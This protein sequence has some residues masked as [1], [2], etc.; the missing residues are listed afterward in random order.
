MDNNRLL[1]AALAYASMGIY[2]FPCGAGSKQPVPYGWGRLSTIDQATIRAWW[3]TERKAFDSWRTKDGK[4][5]HKTFYN[6]PAYNIGIDLARSGFFVVDYDNKNGNN[7][8]A[9]RAE[10]KGP[11]TWTVKTP[12]GGGLHD[13]YRGNADT[14]AGIYAGVDVR[15]RGGL[16]IAPPSVV[17]GVAYTWERAPGLYLLADAD[18]A[19]YNFIAPVPEGFDGQQH[20]PA[21]HVPEAIEQGQRTSA[22]VALA[23]SLIGKGLTPAAAEA[24]IREEN[25][26]RCTPP[27]TDDELML[28]VFPSLRREKWQTGNT[29]PYTRDAPVNAAMLEKLRGIDPANSKRYPWTDNGAARLFMDVCGDVCMYAADAKKW[30]S[31]DGRKWSKDE[32]GARERLRELA[33][34]LT[35]YA[36]RDVADDKRQ[37]FLKWCM[38]WQ[39]LRQRETILKDAQSIAPV[40]V[41]QFD[42]DPLVLNL[43]NGIFSLKDFTIKPH[44]AGALLSHLANV[45][46]DPAA[47]F[48]R[49]DRFIDE[50]TAGDKDTARYL[51][52][53]FGYSLTAETQF[54]CAFL[55]YGPTSRNGKTTLIEA[56]AHMMGDYAMSCDPATLTQR[57]KAKG[58]E[59]SPD[60]VRLYGARLVC[61]GEPPKNMALN[62]ARLKRMT[63]GDTISARDLYESM[64]EYSPTFTIVFNTN[65]LLQVDDLTVFESDRL[66]VVP[67]TVHFSNDK[68][69]PGLK[70][71]FRTPECAAAI[72]NWALEGLRLLR[73]EGFTP[74]R[75]VQEATMD[76]RRTQDKMLRFI[77]D[78][79]ELGDGYE[80]PIVE[81]HNAFGTWCNES[82][83]RGVT[84][85]AFRSMLEER[86][87]Y[88]RKKRPAGTG[89]AGKPIAHTEGIRLIRDS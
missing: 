55:A 19:V 68:R 45:A 31:Y 30:L 88:T 9:R 20:K 89:R 13:W 21:Y 3:G 18:T 41:T 56:V 42:L 12:H 23:G 71:A 52:K 57:D 11:E 24:A 62:A 35:V 63:G 70:E 61:V 10:C 48:P 26:A 78:C 46:Y 29:A 4:K 85:G 83:L 32:N 40:S 6:N 76:Y 66:R 77:E 14:K 38:K 33:D 73:D 5:Q 79:A 22:L 59:V 53:V 67:F 17:D 15:G 39:Q 64:I 50:I 82:G 36:L 37:D 54:E 60:L 58:N 27:L 72:L 65:H 80:T 47:K 25:E 49:W 43:Q 44:S 86:R 8:L 16:V 84:I 75:A 7:G 1:S 81:L 69:D 28:E 34:A 51:Q 2:V 74:P 87:L